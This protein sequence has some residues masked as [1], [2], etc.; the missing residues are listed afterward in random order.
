MFE[1]IIITLPVL[2]ALI[3]GIVQETK[4]LVG[5]EKMKRYNGI[6]AIALGLAGSFLAFYNQQLLVVIGAGLMAGLGATGSY[7]LIKQAKKK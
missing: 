7:E 4:K 1:E 2:A 6:L 3:A 5:E